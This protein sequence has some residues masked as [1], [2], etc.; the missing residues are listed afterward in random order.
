MA[1]TQPAVGRFEEK[2]RLEETENLEVVR[3]R[4]P[5]ET[6][7]VPSVRLDVNGTRNV[8]EQAS[9]FGQ[10]L[11]VRPPDSVVLSEGDP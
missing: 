6:E 7:V 4:G 11:L 9:Q 5:P 10:F 3:A 1:S 8:S 2:A